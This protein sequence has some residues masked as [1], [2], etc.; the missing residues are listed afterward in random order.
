MHKTSLAFAGILLLVA[1]LALILGACSSNKP[2]VVVPA[3][4]PGDQLLASYMVGD[5]CTNREQTSNA[6]R[7]AG[8]SALINVSPEFWRFTEDGNWDISNSGF[9]FVSHGS[10]KLE[11][12]DMLLLAKEGTTPKKYQAQFKNDGADLYLIDDEGQFLVIAHCD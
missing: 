2:T 3:T 10:W 8:L 6:N 7:A 1:G 4:Q 9:V 11:G 5:W 12:L